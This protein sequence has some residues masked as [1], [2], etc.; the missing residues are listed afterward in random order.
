MVRWCSASALP[1]GVDGLSSPHAQLRRVWVHHKLNYLLRFGQA[2]KAGWYVQDLD[3]VVVAF[4]AQGAPRL[5]VAGGW[6]ASLASFP[7]S[8]AFFPP[9]T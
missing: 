7:G 2:P 6:V 1:E 4:R 3:G 5:P 8:D 9:S